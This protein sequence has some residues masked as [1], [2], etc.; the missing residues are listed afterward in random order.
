MRWVQWTSFFVVETLLSFKY[1][2]NTR[3]YKLSNYNN[4]NI[5][6]NINNDTKNKIKSNNPNTD[7]AKESMQSTVSCKSSMSLHVILS[8][9]F[10]FRI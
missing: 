4:N 3:D 5:Q 10:E 9:D 7:S 2:S 6:N 8:I 1:L